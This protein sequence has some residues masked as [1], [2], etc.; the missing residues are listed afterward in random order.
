MNFTA[1]KDK[2][3]WQKQVKGYEGVKPT[4]A[5]VGFSGDNV[6]LKEPAAYD[7]SEW[8]KVPQSPGGEDTDTGKKEEIDLEKQTQKCNQIPEAK[9][10]W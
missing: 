9:E 3:C 5:K 7:R 4:T 6:L 1:E 10:F 2:Y 8:A